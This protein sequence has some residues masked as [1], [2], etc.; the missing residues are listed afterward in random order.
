[1]MDFFIY[2]LLAL[3]FLVLAAIIVIFVTIFIIVIRE[4][5]SVY[6]RQCETEREADT[7]DA[8]V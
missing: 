5:V 1:M 8:T 3:F 2:L 6:S 4:A 7:D